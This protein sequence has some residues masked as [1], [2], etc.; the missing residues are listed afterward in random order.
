M[1]IKRALNNGI[2]VVM[3][4]IPSVQSVSIGIWTKVGSVDE[5]PELYGISHLIEHMLFKGTNQRNAKQIAE[6][7][8]RI[9]GHINAFTGKEATCY[10][11]KT[12]ENN[13]DKACDILI[14]MF[15]DSTFDPIELEKEKKV[16][17]EEIKMIEDSPEDDCSDQLFEVI[18][19]GSD[20][21]SPIIGTFESLA[22][23]TRE[24]IEAYIQKE[25]TADSIV[26]SV[27]GSFD[28][29]HICSLFEGK[30]SRFQKQ[31]EKKEKS[32]P[33]YK[34]DYRVKVKDVE[35]AHL[36]L[37]QKSLPLEDKDYYS[38]TLLN[39]I[40]GGSMSSRL[41]Q[42]IRE[43]KGLA[44]SVYSGTHSYLSDGTFHIYAGVGHDKID[45][46]IEGVTIEVEHL[47]EDGITED[48]LLIA[49]EQL[50]SSF[51]FGQENINNRMYANGK[52][53]LL[54]NRLILPQEV[55]ERIN[56]VDLN[57]IN[58]I[59]N[60]ITNM[61]QYSAVLI[62]NKSYDLKGRMEGLA[63]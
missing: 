23:I 13:V 51:V 26:I 63:K 34:P 24:T 37:G 15:T 56:L 61:N 39:S 30:L 57:Q 14:D 21:E 16:I 8:D 43:Q 20:L 28:E 55:I 19:R 36:C 50:K 29:D 42:T 40:V 45:E 17:Y 2:R 62:S 11:I 33:I 52:N 22:P 38:M 1:I 54:L 18:F 7:V 60:T 41:F 25:Y 10:Y 5:T 6:D 27:A 3:E 31:K 59:S 48:E 9:G 58:H 53:E 32:T 49:K 12:L 46:A 4:R 44:Y 35:Q 47:K